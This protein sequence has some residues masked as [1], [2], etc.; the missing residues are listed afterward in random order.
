MD[1]KVM[2]VN[3]EN[4]TAQNNY[5]TIDAA[6]LRV[7]LQDKTT[8]KNI[9]WCTSDYESYGEGY[10]KTDEIMPE[11][12]SR[13]RAGLIRPRSAK[14]K[15][16]QDQRIK[17]RAEVFTPSWICNIQNNQIDN[18]WFERE[19]VFNTTDG[20]RW[21]VN[22]ETIPFD[23]KKRRWKSYVKENRLEITCGEAPYLVSR[24]DSTT[25]ETI[26]L[27]ERIGLFDRKMRVINENCKNDDEWI[28]W[29][30]RAL[31]SIYGFE[32]QGD[33]LLIARL[34]LFFDYLDYYREKFK[35]DPDIIWQKKIAN[36]IAWNLWQMDGLRFVV[37]YS[38][39]ETIEESLQTVL[40]GESEETKIV[41]CPGC[42]SGDWF[43]HNGIYCRIFD[44][45][46]LKK[47]ILFI[48][49]MR[50]KS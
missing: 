31:K 2:N 21:I 18:S 13:D 15:E 14:A 6:L 12:I 1:E 10:K 46:N 19:N 50:R 49:V 5:F 43:S 36:V 30:L 37:P 22:S 35:K 45:T 32:F 33:N 42:T 17:D 47:S 3:A 25:G 34:N 9:M 7:L 44:W 20:K 24:Y 4:V 28:D 26:P 27:F 38:C 41:P 16:I 11:L 29:S 39:H 8:K 23:A 48:D 40:I